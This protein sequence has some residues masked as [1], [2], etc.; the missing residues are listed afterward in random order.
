MVEWVSKLY[1]GDRDISF[2]GFLESVV[3][4]GIMRSFRIYKFVIV[5]VSFLEI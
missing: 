2:I 3:I 1:F 5:D 4:L